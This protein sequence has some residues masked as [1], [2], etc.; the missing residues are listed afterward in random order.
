MAF[1]FFGFEIGRTKDYG[2][3]LLEPS[4]EFEKSPES[5]VAPETYDGTYTFETGGVFGT[6]VDVGGQNL[7]SQIKGENELIKT[8]RGMSLY[9]EVD[10]AIEDIVNE[11]VV[12][13]D[14]EDSVK[15]D[16]DKVNVSDVVKK[17]IH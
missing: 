15:L 10:M 6:Y 16:L 9:P 13:G 14:S 2:A 1:K 8:Y 3:P 17:N 7:S 5:F 11:S 4:K 12:H